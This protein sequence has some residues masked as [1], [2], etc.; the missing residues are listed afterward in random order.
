MKR[1]YRNEYGDGTVE[2]VE[3]EI[4]EYSTDDEEATDEEILQAVEEVV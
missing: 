2:Y 3:Y 1:T 4:E